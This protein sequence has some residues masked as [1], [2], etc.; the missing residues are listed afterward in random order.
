[1]IHLTSLL[2]PIIYYYIPKSTALSI[3]I[4]LTLLFVLSDTARV[5]HKPLGRLYERYFGFLLRKHERNSSGRRLNGATY[6]LLSAALCMW[7]FPKVIFITA[8]AILIVSDTSAALIGRKFGRH[9]FLS[10][11]LEGSLAFL[12]SALLVIVFS[13]K[14]EYLPLE[15]MIGAIAAL[16]GAIVESA[17]VGVDD[18]LSIP[19]SVGGTMWI[20]YLLLLESLDLYALDKIT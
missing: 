3:L 20:L 4:P 9:P 19:I 18:N 7:I 16:V 13:P 11:T 6:V 8:F 17:S 12:V 15:Y 1:G 10:K 5:L 2:I 14:I